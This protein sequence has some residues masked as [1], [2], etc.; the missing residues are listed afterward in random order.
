MFSKFKYLSDLGA[1]DFEHL[2]G[3]LTS[4]LEGTYSLLKKWG[5]SEILCDAGLFHAAYGTAGF[6]ETMVSL[7]RRSEI[8]ELLG[9]EVEELVYLYCACDREYTYGELIKGS[10]KYR[11]RF[12]SEIFP[13][14]ETQVRA[15]AELTVANEL[16]L[17]ITSEA[18]KAKYGKGLYQLFEGIQPY[19]SKN[20]KSEYQSAMPEYA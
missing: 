3:S 9:E 13:L 6:D 14:E 18:F 17:V 10:G 11:N 16:E 4:H 20:A 8:S 12:T 19:L 1:G 7:D 15:L 2:N 5:C